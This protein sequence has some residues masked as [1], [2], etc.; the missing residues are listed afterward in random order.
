MHLYVSKIFRFWW[1]S[2]TKEKILN[3]QSFL[4]LLAMLLITFLRKEM[5][6]KKLARERIR[7]QLFESRKLCFDIKYE[8]SFKKNVDV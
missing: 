2:I 8:R 6:K 5:T 3:V 7:Q 4:G 1:N